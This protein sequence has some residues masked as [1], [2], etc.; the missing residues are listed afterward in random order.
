MES[1][2]DWRYG[3]WTVVVE[4]GAELAPLVC[5]YLPGHLVPPR[6]LGFPVEEELGVKRMLR[7]VVATWQLT[8][9][10]RP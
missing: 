8:L 5:P 6:V 2:G 10:A 3:P 4:A 9:P 1:P 7:F